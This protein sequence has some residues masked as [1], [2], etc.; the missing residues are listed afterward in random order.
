MNDIIKPEVRPATLED[1]MYIEHL[2]KKESKALGF[3]PKARYEAAITGVR[4]K[5]EECPSCNDAIFVCLENGQHVGYVMGSIWRIGKTAKIHQIVI[6][7]DA[8]LIERG[9]ILLLSFIN[10]RIQQGVYDFSCGC[11]DD[12]DS[13]YFWSSVGWQVVGRRKGIYYGTSKQTSGRDINIYRYTDE[14]VS[15]LL[16]PSATPASTCISQSP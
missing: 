14:S 5:E 9:K 13:N 12:L 6:Q 11:A 7:E 3:I 4:A 10:K 2:S 8:R 1:L 15:P 16:I